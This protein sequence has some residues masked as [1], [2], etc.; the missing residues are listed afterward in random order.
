[1]MET[2]GRLTGTL[3]RVSIRGQMSLEPKTSAVSDTK[4]RR[5]A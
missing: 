1:M 4:T 5:Q 2:S 3:S